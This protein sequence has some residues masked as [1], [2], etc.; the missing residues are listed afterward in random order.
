MKLTLSEDQ[1]FFRETT[2]RFLDDHASVA[3]L[4][5]RRNDAVGFDA[6]YWRRGAELGWTS[7]LVSEADGGGSISGEGLVDLAIV[8]HEFGAHAAPGPLVP[9]NVVAGA[10]SRAGGHQDVLAGLLDGSTTA[11][12]CLGERAARTIVPT[13]L[14]IR[15]DG[16]GFVVDGVKRS[17]ES[18]AQAAHLLVTGRTGDGLTQVLVPAGAPGVTVTALKTVDLTR[19]FSEV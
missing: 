17:V 2:A 6:G 13:G 16:D 19:R 8:A 3:E 14:E 9:V 15:P 7:F 5:R 4:R 1:L 11:A 18:A 10:L 12:W